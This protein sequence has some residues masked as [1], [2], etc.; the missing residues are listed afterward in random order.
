MV[1]RW[2]AREPSGRADASVQTIRCDGSCGA[3]A[4]TFRRRASAAADHP[5]APVSRQAAVDQLRAAADGQ[6]ARAARARRVLGL[7]PGQL[8]A[9][10]ALPQGM[11]RPLRG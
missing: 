9:H 6:A 11:A 5:G 1:W 2:G 10:A 8:A 7:L 4:A 3:T